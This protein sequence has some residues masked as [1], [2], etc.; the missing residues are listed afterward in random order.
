ME[1]L[2]SVFAIWLFDYLII[3]LFYYSTMTY[4][5]K[6][7]QKKHKKTLN[8]I[9]ITVCIK[10]LSACAV[11]KKP[12]VRETIPASMA[13]GMIL[14]RQIKNRQALT[15]RARKLK[16]LD[17]RLLWIVVRNSWFLRSETPRGNV[18]FKKPA[19]SCVF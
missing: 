13:H 9:I 1:T 16:S 5:S 8:L 10:V 14:L 12:R 3:L 6:L 18:L 19:F 11:W 4:Q 7:N 17:Q 2:V 15:S